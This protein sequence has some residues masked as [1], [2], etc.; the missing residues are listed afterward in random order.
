V[1]VL[2]RAFYA[3]GDTARPVQAS[4]VSVA[5]NLALNLA[6]MGPLQHLGLALSTSITAIANFLQLAF[7]LRRKVGALE[8]GRILGT[9]AR[10]LAAS[11]LALAP[12]AAALLW[13]GERW[14][15]GVATEALMVAAGG[16]IALALGY[17][18]LRALRVEEL[19][20]LE[21]AARSVR[22]RIAGR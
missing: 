7:Y 19:G 2:T 22:G 14:H 5:L 4:F 17:V 1:G 15:R 12:V 11:A 8:G 6:L 13:L 16:V 10:V 3:L 18:A 20:A 21:G 9:L